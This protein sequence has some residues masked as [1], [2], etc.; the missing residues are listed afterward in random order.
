MA[1]DIVLIAIAVVVAAAVGS[2]LPSLAR[3]AAR[4]SRPE[5]APVREEPVAEPSRARIEDDQVAA[6]ARAL[7][8]ELMRQERY[9]EGS[10]ILDDPR[11]GEV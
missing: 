9:H 3:R 10:S 2:T 6:T 8:A 7:A 5:P 1:L 4:S 11:V